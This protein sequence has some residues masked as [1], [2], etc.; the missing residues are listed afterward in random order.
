MTFEKSYI[1][2]LYFILLFLK[3]RTKQPC[4]IQF[5]RKGKCLWNEYTENTSSLQ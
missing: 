1:V 4:V 2:L 5:N 3:F